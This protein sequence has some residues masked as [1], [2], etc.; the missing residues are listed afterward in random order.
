MP[1][2]DRPHRAPRGGPLPWRAGVAALALA[3]CGVWLVHDGA[4]GRHG[5]PLPPAPSVAAG[6]PAAATSVTAPAAAPTPPP[7]PAAPPMP[8]S[9][10][11]RIRIPS[12][13]VDAPV[14][15]LGLTAARQLATPPMDQRNLTGWYRDGTAPGAAGNAIV[16]GHADN[17]SG[18]AVFYRLGLLRPGDPIEV[19]RKDRHTAV[20]TVDSVRVFPKADFPDALVYEA[21]I[22]DRAELRLITC[23]GKFDRKTGYESN[24]VV[25]AHLSSA[26]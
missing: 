3:M 13:Q 14:T 5:P 12:I 10:P 2:P 22:P 16:V 4:A 24:T 11:T 9:A 23:G 8:A 25:F 26:R 17:R 20:F 6:S 21:R 15:G 19:A 7:V 1:S 18:P